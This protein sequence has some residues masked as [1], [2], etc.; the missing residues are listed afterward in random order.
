MDLLDIDRLLVA[1]TPAEPSGPNLEYTSG[2]GELERA[3]LG[4]P[5]SVLGDA[6]R[7]AEPPQW[8]D[9]ERRAVA[10][11]LTSKDLRIAVHL[12]RALLQLHGLSG[13][14]HG[15]KLIDGLLQNFWDSVHP[16]LDAE[17][18]NDPTL[19]IN[20]LAALG[21]AGATL[22]LLRDTPLVS[23]PRVGRFSLRDLRV[24]EGRLTPLGDGPRASL[25]EI[26][27]A[28]LEVSEERLTADRDV[29]AASRALLSAIEQRFDEAV[30]SS[31]DFAPL[32][33]DLY[34]IERF[35]SAQLAKRQPDV[36]P[37]AAP[38]DA[39]AL[40]AARGGAPSSL[41]DVVRRLDEI[42]LFYARTEPSSPVP[43]LLERAKRLV[44]KDFLSIIEDL[45]PG[46]LA[47]ARAVRGNSDG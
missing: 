5:E 38:V 45:V 37:G 2:F 10:L 24:A 13:F 31:P 3:A 1:V 22:R 41:Q 36:A 23:A 26:E 8:S 47:E 16:Q 40:T 34:D 39:P 18:D 14:A 4:T 29:A 44:G 42:C 9:V 46:G 27:A 21:D 43:L 30:G 6:V 7:P 15:V 17:D 25:A 32:R 11:L 28:A 19:R 33:A 12:S 35:L 20:S